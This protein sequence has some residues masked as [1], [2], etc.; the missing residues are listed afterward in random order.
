M[1]QPSPSQE[2]VK[3]HNYH[4]HGRHPSLGLR[5]VPDVLWFSVQYV[6][7]ASLTVL[8]YDWALNFDHEISLVWQ[9]RWSIIKAL[10][11]ITRYLAFG[12]V[13]LWVY[14]KVQRQILKVCRTEI[15]APAI[16]Q[17]AEGLTAR[18]CANL[19][20]AFGWT[21]TTGFVLGELLLVMRTWAVWGRDRKIG[22]GIFAFYIGLVIP[23][24]VNMSFFL[25]GIGFIDNIYRGVPGCIVVKSSNRLY[26]DW[27]L[28]MVLDIGIC[29]LMIVKGCRSYVSGGNSQLMKVVYGEGIVYYIYLVCEGSFPRHQLD[30][31][32]PLLA[33]SMINVILI[34]KLPAEYLALLSS[35]MRSIHA[36]LTCRVV[37]H[38][39][40]QARI[41][42]IVLGHDASDETSTSGPTETL[43]F[44]GTIE[45]AERTDAEALP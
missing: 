9:S 2:A 7:L 45:V 8:A 17:V 1:T 13:T 28:L 33:F 31:T 12:D 44:A 40:E 23:I 22:A 37:L 38:T 43:R 19:F 41:K 4:N 32:H 35:P 25:K 29:A 26:V 24:Y 27:V 18:K 11:L 30:G 20:T 42:T 6:N 10:Y 15:E 5:L 39:R 36:I 16:E 14:G 34:L 21:F 3:D